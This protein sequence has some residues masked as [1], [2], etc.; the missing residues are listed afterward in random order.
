MKKLLIIIALFGITKA[1]AQ[2]WSITGNTGTDPTLN[3]I[4]TTDNTAFKIKTFDQVRIQIGGTGNVKIGSGV[5]ATKLDVA[6][7]ITATGGNSTNWN[8]AFGWGNH[9]A[10]GYVTAATETDPQVGTISTNNIPKWNASQL[11]TSVLWESSS[12]IGIGTAAPTAALHISSVDGLLVAGTFGSGII[13]ASGAGLRLMWFP[14]KGAFRAGRVLADASVPGDETLFWNEDSIGNYSF[15]AGLNVKAKG[16]TSIALGN[17]CFASG[18]NSFAAGKYAEAIGTNAVSIGYSTLAQENYSMAI[19][20]F[21]TTKGTASFASGINTLAEGHYSASFNNQTWS[22]GDNSFAAGLLS[23]SV[24][25]NSSAFG[26]H[27]ISRAYGSTVVGMYNDSLEGDPY[28]SLTTNP[29]FIVGNGNSN[30][31]RSN[32]FMVFK[33]GTAKIGN[34]T[35]KDDLGLGL[36]IGGD[37]LPTDNDFYYVGNSTYRYNT[38]YCTNGTINT[39]DV[40]E[41]NNINNLYYG[42]KELMKLRPVTFNWNEHP[43]QGTKIGLIAQELQKIIPEVVVDKDWSKSENGK[44]AAVPATRLGV[45]YSDL[46]PVLIKGF[47]EQVTEKEELK[48]K[49]EALE[50]KNNLMVSLMDELTSKLNALEHSLAECCVSINKSEFQPSEINQVPS[51]EQNIPNPFT[52]KTEIKYYIPQSVHTSRLLISDEHGKEI[53]NVEIKISGNGSYYIQGNEL[54]PGIYFYTLTVDDQM[55][56][57]RKM[58]L[59]K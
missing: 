34:K 20:N 11:V 32:A 17:Y 55:K 47:Q 7:I 14:K 24:G 49:I 9:S 52:Q 46:I 27:S 30:T 23:K 37:V 10:A 18:N 5:A 3:F 59:T 26:I 33:D 4:G 21:T 12:R 56:L 53:R 58:I 19:N 39:S 25:E 45:Y 38:I 35:L 51:L 6:G 8:T 16:T 43:E 29:L 42:T 13:P 44:R 28:V 15:A 41:K 2:D 54:S 22:D 50:V 48:N 57:T 36:L 31:S 1:N 40:H